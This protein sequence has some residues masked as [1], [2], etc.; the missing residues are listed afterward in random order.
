[1]KSVTINGIKYDLDETEDGLMI[2]FISDVMDI[3]IQT[4][5]IPG[6]IE[7]NGQKYIPYISI[8]RLRGE[9]IK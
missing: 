8:Y 1:M 7:A 3:D 4:L 2:G 5:Y 6:S 9:P